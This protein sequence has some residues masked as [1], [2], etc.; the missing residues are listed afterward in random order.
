[1]LSRLAHGTGLVHTLQYDFSKH[2]RTAKP[3][4]D[5]RTVSKDMF[6]VHAYESGDKRLYRSFVL[7]FNRMIVLVTE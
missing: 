5:P 7:S 1:M 2:Y 3:V 6:S 4:N